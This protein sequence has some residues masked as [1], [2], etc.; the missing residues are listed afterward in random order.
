MEQMNR[1]IHSGKILEVYIGNRPVS[2]DTFPLLGEL[3]IPDIWLLT[4]TYRDGLHESPAIAT[5]FAKAFFD[6]SKKISNF[7]SPERSFISYLTKQK[8][9]ELTL[10][11]YIAAGYE[12]QMHLPRMGWSTMFEEMMREKILKIYNSLGVDIGLPPDLLI[13]IIKNPEFYLPYFKKYFTQTL[14][15]KVTGAAN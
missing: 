6:K 10:A 2:I 5:R 3:S 12:H 1:K 9:I 11:H 15:Y 14:D 7:F 8:S 13:M 4:G